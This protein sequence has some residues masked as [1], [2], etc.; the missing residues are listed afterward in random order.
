MSLIKCPNCGQEQNEG[1]NFCSSCGYKLVIADK[2]KPNETLIRCPKCGQEQ[3]EGMNFCSSCG[4]KL[5]IAGETK[6]DETFYSSERLFS[7]IRFSLPFSHLSSAELW[8]AIG[9][10]VLGIFF[11]AVIT[12][13]FVYFHLNPLLIVYF[14]IISI[15][16]YA[17]SL[18][19]DTDNRTKNT[20]ESV[21]DIL[22]LPVITILMIKFHC[23]PFLIGA[24]WLLEIALIVIKIFINQENKLTEVIGGLIGCIYLVFLYNGY[25]CYQMI[26]IVKQLSY[27]DTDYK[28]VLE[29]SMEDV[30]WECTKRGRFTIIDTTY[31]GNGG[32]FDAVVTV[33]GKASDED[34]SFPLELVFNVSKEREKAVL[35]GMRSDENE[36]TDEDDMSTIIM[37]LYLTAYRNSSNTDLNYDNQ[38]FGD[39]S[40]STDASS[41]LITPGEYRCY[42]YESGAGVFDSDDFQEGNTVILRVYSDN[43]AT[44]YRELYWDEGDYYDHEE[45]TFYLTYD[46]DAFYLDGELFCN[47]QFNANNM[48]LDLSYMDFESYDFVID[49]Y[50]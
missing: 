5:V 43:T 47:Y 50:F 28:T 37:A 38:D 46:E 4:Y 1:M 8:K 34:S 49:E 44:L 6:P 13:F 22:G 24:L 10:V 18:F 29:N 14:W 16:S 48:H 15:G 41:Y 36:I 27:A 2:S 45:N 40:D 25:Q 20:L 3:N 7:H 33:S 9:S 23:E 12:Y 42:Y 39:I 26:D 17:T 19:I 31:D 32:S 35:V 30:K 11:L 21:F